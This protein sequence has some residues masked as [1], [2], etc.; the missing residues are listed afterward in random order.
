MKILVPFFAVIALV[1]LAVIGTAANLHFLFGAVIP[2]AALFIFIFGVIYRVLKWAKSP[3]PFCI[4]TTCGQQKSLPWIKQNKLE[5][6]S[7]TLHVIGRMALEVLTF[8]SLFRNIK[9]ELRDG[10]KFVYGSDKWL[11]LGGIAFH[12]AFLIVLLRHIR[13]FAEP[14]PAYLYILEAF[15]GFLQ[16]GIPR[17]FA[18]GVVLLAAAA[19]LFL[20]RIY[21]PQ[22]RYIS[23]AADY[24]P[25]FLIMG[26]AATGIIMRY[27]FKTD[28]VGVKELAMGLVGFNPVIPKSVGSIFYVHLLLVSALFAY[29][30]FSKLMHMGGVFLSPTRNMVANSR[31][32]R[33]VN[34]WNY[35]VKVHTYE[36]YEEDFREKMKMAEIPVEKE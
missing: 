19:F 34:P 13:L 33:H 2:Y 8:R 10:S 5:N 4:P 16:I 7:G 35:P 36:E 17:L 15:D 21:V 12:Y 18:T 3:V 28:I 31:E 6:P 30:P 24:F 26:I 11:W 29:F 1:L 25:L 22:V 27:F 14:T 23:L 20:R 32:F 9:G